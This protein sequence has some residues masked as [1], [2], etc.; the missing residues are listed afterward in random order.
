VLVDFSDGIEKDSYKTR[1]GVRVLKKT[2]AED[3]RTSF[4]IEDKGEVLDYSQCHSPFSMS[5]RKTCRR[6]KSSGTH[7]AREHVPRRH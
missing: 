5:R 2:G 6:L 1:R 3:G 7:F 4:T